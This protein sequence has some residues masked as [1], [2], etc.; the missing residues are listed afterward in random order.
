MQS[1]ELNDWMA[2]FT[3]LAATARLY[4]AVFDLWFL[5]AEKLRLEHHVVR[6]EDLIADLRGTAAEAMKFIGLEWD[7]RMADFHQHAR[8][9]GHLSTPSHAQVTQPV[10]GHAVARWKRYGGMM[11]ETARLLKPYRS[12]LGYGD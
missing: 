12:A 6:Y 9:R 2:V 5:T 7:D 10:Y 1:F 3:D 11:D 8:E 4:G